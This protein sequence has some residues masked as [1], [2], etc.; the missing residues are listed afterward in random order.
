M[1]LGAG[2]TFTYTP[3]ATFSG[4]D[5]FTYTI[6]DTDGETSTATVT[7]TVANVANDP[8]V[9]IVP[10]AQ[11]SAEDV[12]LVFS[13][14]T[15]NL[16]AVSDPDA[17]ANPLEVTLTA[18][19]G[20]LTLARHRRAHVHRRRRHGRRDDDVHRHAA[21]INAALD[22]MSFLPPLDYSG[23][24]SVTITTGDLGVDRRRRAAVRQRHRRHHG[25]GRR[26]LADARSRRQQQLRRARRRLCADLHRRVRLGPRRRRRRTASPTTTA[27]TSP[28]SRSRSPTSLTVWTR[29]LPRTPPARRSPQ[30][31]S[32]APAS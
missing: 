7:V 12:A 2:N 26:R 28:R 6:Q 17:G 22:G 13:L 18:I 15:G 16:I 19:Q 9:N 21:A 32:R 10:G 14:G 5:T 30:A 27:R 8:P 1:V 20:T 4:I 3:A 31:S 11:I 23:P 25:G 29:S 24:A